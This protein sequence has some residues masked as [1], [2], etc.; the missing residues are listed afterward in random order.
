LGLGLARTP[1]RLRRGRAATRPQAL[2]W[3]ERLGRPRR[4]RE[5]VDVAFA[6]HPIPLS[7][8]SKTP[9]GP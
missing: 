3:R 6:A 7:R 4:R 8:L 2:S 1:Q 5:H 9:R